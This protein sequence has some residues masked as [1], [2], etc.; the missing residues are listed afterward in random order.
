MHCCLMYK[1]H[2][3]FLNGYYILK[4]N[5]FPRQHDLCRLASFCGRKQHHC[6]DLFGFLHLQCE[7]LWA[8]NRDLSRVNWILPCLFLPVDSRIDSMQSEIIQNYIY[9]W[10]LSNMKEFT[11][12]VHSS[13]MIICMHF[14]VVY[15]IIK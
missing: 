11:I 5:Q 7:F 14:K 6:K 1:W 8:N 13:V 12:S 10:Y 9:P 2:Q 15:T 4:I 3:P